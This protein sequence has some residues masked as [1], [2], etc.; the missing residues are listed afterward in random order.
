MNEKERPLR[1]AVGPAP[2]VELFSNERQVTARTPPAFLAHALDDKPVP[3][4]NSRA[5]F[6]ALRKHAV[7]T[8]Y[9]ELPS[10]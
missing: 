9:L 10:G 6:E 3:P 1:F 5:F 4:A 7:A 8:E 2:L